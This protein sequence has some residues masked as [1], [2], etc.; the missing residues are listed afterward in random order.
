MENG[1]EHIY[2][3]AADFC[4]YLYFRK[5]QLFSILQLTFFFCFFPE[6]FRYEYADNSCHWLFYRIIPRKCSLCIRHACNL[7]KEF[8]KSGG[9]DDKGHK[10]PPRLETHFGGRIITWNY[11]SIWRD[12]TRALH[13]EGLSRLRCRRHS[14]QFLCFFFAFFVHPISFIFGRVSPDHSLLVS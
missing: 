14:F 10:C 7:R 4:F 8:E 3:T 11:Y 9:R 13:V 6:K 12:F 5:L 2:H 1:S